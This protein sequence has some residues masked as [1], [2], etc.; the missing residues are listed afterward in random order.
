MVFF[1]D[2]LIYSATYEDHLKH[3]KKVFELLAIDQWKIKLS[4]CTFAQNQIAYLGMLSVRMGFPLILLRF[5][6]LL[7]RLHHK[8][9]K[10]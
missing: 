3:L 7:T 9:L 1:D 5:L 6:L 10:N 8:M 2:I 4:R